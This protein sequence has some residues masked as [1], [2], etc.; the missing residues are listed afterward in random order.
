MCRCGHTAHWHGQEP[1]QE[2][3]SGE[4]EGGAECV[5]KRFQPHAPSREAY[6]VGRELAYRLKRAGYFP[7]QED[8]R[9]GELIDGWVRNKVE[10]I[11]DERE[12]AISR[13]FE[14]EEGWRAR[15]ARFLR[16]VAAAAEGS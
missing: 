8:R 13:Q 10:P 2:P 3:G 15:V 6:Q 4:C 12:E 7:E 11:I 14:L 16:R 5:C 9:A 1:G